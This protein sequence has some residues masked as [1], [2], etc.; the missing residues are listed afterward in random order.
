MLTMTG[1]GLACCLLAA[2]CGSAQPAGTV[3]GNTTAKPAASVPAS[4]SSQPQSAHRMIKILVIME[5]NHSVGQVFPSHMPYLWSLASRYGRATAWSDVGHPS[6]PNYLA[7]FGGS[8]FGDPQDCLPG[9]GCSYPGPTVF[10]QAKAKSE[11]ARAYEESM[12]T[13]CDLSDS[14]NYDV[15]H[16]PWAYFPSEASICR[17]DDVPAGTVAGGPLVSDVRRGTLPTVGLI[18]PNLIDD[19]HNG[20]L[21]ESDSWLRSWMPVL[22]SGPDWRSGRLAIVVVFD[23]GETTEQVPFVIVAPGLSGAVIRRPLNHY[24]LTRLID[25]VAGT[26]LLGQAARAPSLASLLG[27]RL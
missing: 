22:M 25:Q 15:N 6:L 24:A 3:T 10:G 26:V 19:A 4:A 9:P 1:V 27:L 8:S 12:P 11:T 17:A 23:E 21:A 5:E 13:P 14:G 20:T 16:N 18:T 7:I 2:G